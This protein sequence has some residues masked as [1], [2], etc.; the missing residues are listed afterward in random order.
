MDNQVIEQFWGKVGF[1]NDCW[2]WMGSIE[3]SGYGIFNLDKKHIRAHRFAYELVI[4]LIPVDKVLDHTCH[5]QDKKCKEGLFCLHRRCINPSH[6]EPTTRLNN[7]L[8]GR[9]AELAALRQL[10][11]TK[12]PLGHIFSKEN[13]YIRKDRCGRECR[14]CRNIAVKRYTNRRLEASLG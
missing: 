11:K 8:R 9:V 1:T 14:A 6:L 12:C 5:N 2:Y 10:V 7:S 3:K 13:T 4:G